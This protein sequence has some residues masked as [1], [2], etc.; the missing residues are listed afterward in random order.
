[1]T[2]HRVIIVGAGQGGLQAAI[3][4]RQFG[5]AGSVTLVGLEPDLPYQRPPLSKA[6]LLD[7]KA[8]AL[9]LRP[10]SFFASKDVVYL[11]GT[12]VESIDRTAKEI[13]VTGEDGRRNLPYDHMIL[14]TG[15]RNMRPPIAGL[16]HTCDLRTL[17][18]AKVLRERLAQPQRIA[19]IGGGF[20]GLEFAAVARKLGHEI[21]VIETAPRLMARA[22]SHATSA[23]FARF[24]SDLGTGLHFGQ[25]AT[26]VTEKCVTLADGTEIS[27]NFVLLAAGVRPNSELADKAGLANFN[28][29]TV[30]ENLFTSDPDISALGDCASFPD[31][32][33]G[34]H[35]RLESVQAATDHARLIAARIVNGDAAPYTALPWFWSD[36]GDQKLQI[37]GYADAAA[38]EETITDGVVARF[39]QSGL[40]AIETVNNAR[41]HMKA[42]RFLSNGQQGDLSELKGIIDG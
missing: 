20:I 4:L 33:T 27:A 35:I 29:I 23:H 38:T 5:Y 7:G 21:S 15:T 19:I 16:E 26:A 30:D 40:V 37:A 13:T 3:S 31:P 28:G 22:V 25:P 34:K 32:R 8:D 6:Y 41:I 1:M 36:Q 18:D 2:Q 12:T 10:A 9:T 17:A 42:R 11:S 39:N 24:H 14:A